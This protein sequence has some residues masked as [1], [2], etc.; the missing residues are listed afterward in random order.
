[1]NDLYKERKK[2]IASIKSVIYERKL[3]K[4]SLKI[5]Q[6]QSSANLEKVDSLQQMKSKESI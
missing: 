5:D 6:P 2:I 3:L 1:L 4:D